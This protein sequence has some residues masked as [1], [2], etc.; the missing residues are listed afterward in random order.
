M[1]Q[2]TE[3]EKQLLEKLVQL[4]QSARL[5]ELQVATLLRKELNCF[6]LRWNIEPNKTL[7]FI[8]HE[9]MVVKRLIGMH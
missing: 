1:R 4:K 7:V 9:T 5:E 8:L 3:N 6:A 2:I